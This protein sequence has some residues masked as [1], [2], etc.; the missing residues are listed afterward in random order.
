M[1]LH[2]PNA[3]KSIESEHPEGYLDFDRLYKI[4]QA[5][6][7]FVTRAKRGMNARRVYSARPT[8]ARE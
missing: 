4:H 1:P 2:E 8:E 5:G 6:A 3:R 7:F